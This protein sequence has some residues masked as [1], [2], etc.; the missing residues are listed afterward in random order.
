MDDVAVEQKYEEYTGK[1]SNVVELDDKVGN[2]YEVRYIDVFIYIKLADTLM[3]Q[4]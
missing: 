1:E 3:N 2:I 4:F